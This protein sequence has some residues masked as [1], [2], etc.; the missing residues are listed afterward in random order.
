MAQS[1]VGQQAQNPPQRLR[2][3]QKAAAIQD[4]AESKMPAKAC[5]VAEEDRIEMELNF[6]RS[7]SDSD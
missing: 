4:H 3:D 5:K 6:N 7:L 2:A 1:G